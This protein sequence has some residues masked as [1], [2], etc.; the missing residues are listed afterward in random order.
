MKAL[1]QLMTKDQLQAELKKK[2]QPGIKPSHL[3]KSKSLSAIPATPPLPNTPLQKSKSQLEIPTQQPTPEQQIT[4]LQDQI[5]FHAQTAQNYLQ[6]LQLAQAK[7]SELEAELQAKETFIDAPEEN[8]AELKEKISQLEEQILQLRLDKI[9]EF[10]DYLE[11]KKVLENE[12]T[13]NI[14]AGTAEL[15]RL[16]TKLVTTNKK[17]LELAHKLGTAESK[18]AQLELQ[19]LA[20]Q[21]PSSNSHF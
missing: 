16:E 9:K 20:N 18:N 11:K 7:I 8:P 5:K 17:K 6:S 2:V 15:E 3:R 21:E 10:A 19:L 14:T 4:Q 12:L 13:E 1:T